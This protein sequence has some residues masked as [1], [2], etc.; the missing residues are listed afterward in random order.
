M[1]DSENNLP[2]KRELENG[3][4][5]NSKKQMVDLSTLENLT[6]VNNVEILNAKEGAFLFLKGKLQEE[7]AIFKLRKSMPKSTELTENLGEFSLKNKGANKAWGS[8]RA[9]YPSD[10]FDLDIFVPAL[11]TSDPEEIK[12]LI[13]KQVKKLSSREYVFV[14]ETSERYEK[15]TKPYI[16]S[17]PP[18]DVQWVHNIVD[19]VK[20][21]G[22]AECYDIQ[23]E[24]VR[25]KVIFSDPD[26]QTGFAL[27]VDFKWKSHPKTMA[28]LSEN[29]VKDGKAVYGILFPM[30]KDI[31]TLRDLT[32]EHL[33][34]LRNV[35]AQTKASMEKLYGVPETK[36]RL[37]VHYQPQ[38][39]Y[40]HVHATSMDIDFGIETERG[41]LLETI[42]SNLEIDSDYYQKV[43]LVYKVPD[44]SALALEDSAAN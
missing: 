14:R 40:F 37:F 8:Y 23:E 38:F 10:G 42:I 12:S 19:N 3:D 13:A 27:L 34:F 4:Q 28:E 21:D 44:Y 6:D 11:E 32:A 39:Y 26:P 24:K 1:A 17:I 35:E 31:R 7:D 2:Q 20:P 30:R 33:P 5:T 18:K 43:T 16:D 22:I 29:P 36:L 9:T 25:E 15:V 41:H